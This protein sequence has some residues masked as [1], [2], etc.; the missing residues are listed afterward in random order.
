MIWSMKWKT[1]TR[2]VSKWPATSSV[3][4]SVFR[5]DFTIDL[6]KHQGAPE[7]CFSQG[8]ASLAWQKHKPARRQHVPPWEFSLILLHLFSIGSFISSFSLISASYIAAIRG[9]AFILGS[10]IAVL[11]H[12]LSWFSLHLF[13]NDSVLYLYHNM[14]CSFHPQ[15]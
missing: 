4:T 8:Q 6:L 13:F 1:S 14:A 5:P 3:L 9:R 2:R 12:A 10:W 11:I 7:V 15:L